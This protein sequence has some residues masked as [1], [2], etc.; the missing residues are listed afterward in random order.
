MARISTRIRLCLPEP[1][2]GEHRP[3]PSDHRDSKFAPPSPPDP[4]SP[5]TPPSI[6]AEPEKP[7]LFEIW[8]RNYLFN[9]YLLQSVWRMLGWR[10][11]SVE[12]YY[13][14]SVLWIR[15][16]NLCLDPDLE[17]G[18]LKAGSGSGI[19]HSRSQHC[20]WYYCYIT[21]LSKNKY[22]AGAGAENMDNGG[23]GAVDSESATLR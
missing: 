3:A 5:F 8:S 7:K 14:W 16:R 21:V 23:A 6:L 15:I 18:K 19:N 13:F 9:K 1:E 10:K 2:G 11:T 22:M 12:T 20:F 4:S 17:L